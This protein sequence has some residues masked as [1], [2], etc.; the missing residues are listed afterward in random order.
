MSR[1]Q[2]LG[3]AAVGV[4]GVALL[5]P[6]VAGAAS[7]TAPLRPPGSVTEQDFV[8]LCIRCTACQRACP[9]ETLRPAGL[10]QGFAGYN[11]PVLSARDGGCEYGC[12][13][14]G[15]VC[16]TGAIQPLSLLAKQTLQLGIARVDESRCLPIAKGKPCMSC[17]AACPYE[18]IDLAPLPRELHWGDQLTRPIVVDDLCTGCGL[19]EAACPVKGAAAIRVDALPTQRPMPPKS[20]ERP[21]KR[22]VEGVFLLDPA[23]L[24]SGNAP[25][26]P[27]K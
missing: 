18:A 15:L 1:R 2:L 7:T 10:A 27:G 26:V 16:P 23:L 22:S 4:A 9:T 21:F 19:C 20:E 11:A 14:C 6:G 24:D 5:Q 17:S 13:A 12:N 8:D 25:A 3:S